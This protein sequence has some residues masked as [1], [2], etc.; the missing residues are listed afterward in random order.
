MVN[1]LINL[2]RTLKAEGILISFSGRFSQGIIEE[3]GEAIK[4]HMED[5]DYPRNDIYNVFAIFVEQTHNI[6]NYAWSKEG[7]EFYDKIIASG[8]ITIGKNEKGYFVSSG[9]LI[10]NTDT[11][12]LAARIDG[13]RVADKQELKQRYKEQMKKE[14][15]P[16]SMGAGVGLIDIA[17]KASLPITYSILKVD[18][19]LSFFTLTVAV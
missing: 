1:Q 14:L 5:E 12:D 7:T 10:E 6:K 15:A 3:L 11:E 16:G 19:Q 17:R 8:I 9:N 4:K 13:I 18:E 2:Q